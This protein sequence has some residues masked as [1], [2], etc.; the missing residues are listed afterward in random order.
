MSSRELL[1]RLVDALP[2]ERLTQAALDLAP[3][4]DEDIGPEDLAA[5]AEAEAAYRDGSWRGWPTLEQVKGELG[6][7][8]SRPA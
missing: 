6:Q 3:D 1:H 8:P 5:I 2:E 7:A 4:D